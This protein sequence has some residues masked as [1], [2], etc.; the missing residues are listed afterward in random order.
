[1]NAIRVALMDGR[2]VDFRRGDKIDFTVPA[3][4]IPNVTKYTA[5]YPL[6]PGHGLD[7]FVLRFRGDARGGVGS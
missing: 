4:P 6:R 5:G 1:M 7:R 3:I 2:V